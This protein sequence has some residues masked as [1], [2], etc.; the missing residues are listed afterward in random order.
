MDFSEIY[1][2]FLEAAKL[3]NEAQMASDI[4]AKIQQYYRTNAPGG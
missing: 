3:P 1:S 4:Q 2:E